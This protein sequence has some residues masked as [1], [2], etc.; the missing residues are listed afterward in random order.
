LAG[1]IGVPN[2]GIGQGGYYPYNTA[3]DNTVA[4]APTQL[5]FDGASNL[6]IRGPIY[7]DE[8]S[9][10]DS[11]TNGANIYY[12]PFAN[13]LS[14]TT[15]SNI[16]TTSG[17]F[18]SSGIMVGDYIKLSSDAITAYAQVG[19]ILNDTTLNLYT[20]YTGS[21]AT[22]AAIQSRFQPVIGTGGTVS[23]ANSILTI[24]AGT[25]ANSATYITRSV[26]FVPIILVFPGSA[27]SQCI[28]NQTF[29]A[30]IMDSITTP[31]VGAYFTYSGTN[32]TQITTV[33]Q[34]GAGA[35]NTESYT[36][37]L[38]NSWTNST[39]HRL[40]VELT[41]E[42]AIFMIDDIP[43]ATHKTQIP[44]SYIVLG[45]FYGVIN[46]AS[47]PASN[48]NLITD[49]IFVNNL[50][51]VQVQFG[52]LGSNMSPCNATS[53]MPM[54]Q[55]PKAPNQTLK[56]FTG[57][58][59]TSTSVTTVQTL[60][61]TVTTGK[62]F[63]LTD[64]ISCNNST[65]PSVVSV[66]TSLTASTGNV[67]IGHSQQTSPINAINIGSEPACPSGSQMSVQAGATAAATQIT[68][69]LAGYEQ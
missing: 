1:N 45:I 17:G 68:Y 56:S 62:T 39:S 61:Y 31:T 44:P 63:Y 42:Y 55:A 47:A 60:S 43:I 64:F 58:I 14:F 8:G 48:T 24:G 18:L 36:W 37:T 6:Q 32:N 51:T 2:F 11:F 25:T 16:V 7:T 22:G 69:F 67:L 3:F 21:T 10:R 57:T 40:R 50:D 4:N 52:F 33:T 9:I 38:P 20:N 30:G 13:T 28:A 49:G 46:G 27:L 19:Q 34:S 29:Y 41:S 65:N 15:G 5:S 23:V 54:T 35:S 66:N 59:T 26:D 53:P 12:S